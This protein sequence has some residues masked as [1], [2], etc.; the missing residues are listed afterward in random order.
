[1]TGR[2]RRASTSSVETVDGKRNFYRQETSLLKSV[3]KGTPDIDWPTYELRDAVVLN[4]DG[5]TL[6]SA[7]D[8]GSKGPFTIRGTL[9]LDEPGQRRNREARSL[10]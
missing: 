2:T 1:M 5:E 10:C 7:L 9:M 4:K 3:S 6:E 8:V